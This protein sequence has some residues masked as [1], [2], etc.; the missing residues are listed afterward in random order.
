MSAERMFAK[1]DVLDTEEDGKAHTAAH[2]S[3]MI[4]RRP[5][6]SEIGSWYTLCGRVSYSRRTDHLDDTAHDRV[7]ARCEAAAEK[8]TRKRRTQR[9]ARW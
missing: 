5:D 6:E 8:A 9:K 1:F 4:G 7:C 3:W 2:L